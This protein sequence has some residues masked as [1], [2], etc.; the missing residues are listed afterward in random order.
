MSTKGF[1]KLAICVILTL[2]IACISST[3]VAQAGVWDSWRQAFVWEDTTFYLPWYDEASPG[4]VHDIICIANDY[5]P[6][7]PLSGYAPAV[8]YEVRLAGNPVNWGTIEGGTYKEVRLPG[9]IGGPIEVNASGPISVFEKTYYGD[10]GCGVNGYNVGAAVPEAAV[11]STYLF[12]WYEGHSWIFVGNPQDQI[13]QYEVRVARRVHDFGFMAP[14]SVKSC[15]LAG[16]R[17]GPVEINA[18]SEI[19]AS[20]RIVFDRSMDEVEGAPKECVA[21][22]CEFPSCATAS[23]QSG[24]FRPGGPIAGSPYDGDWIFIGNPNG[25]VVLFEIRDQSGGIKGFG[26]IAPWTVLSYYVS[27]LSFIPPRPSPTSS[28]IVNAS[29]PI[30]AARRTVGNTKLQIFTG[31]PK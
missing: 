25:Q 30:Y 12:P 10:G 17:G 19:Y 18:S 2:T 8:S 1:K 13:V 9:A 31:I 21:T 16:V 28:F 27:P 4:M 14:R 3:N 20:Q 22:T 29:D 11:S 7:P 6:I 23:A 26:T 24:Y 15:F 5:A